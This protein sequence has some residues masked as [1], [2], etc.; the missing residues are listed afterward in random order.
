MKPP[1][2][3]L[4]WQNLEDHVRK[5]ASL[6]WNCPARPEKVNGVRLDAV[7]KT[8]Q[9]YWIIIEISRESKLSKLRNDLSKFSSVRPHLFEKGIYAKSF[10]CCLKPTESLIETGRGQNVEVLSPSELESNFF[11]YES[12]YH[13]RSSQKFGSA[14]DPYSGE[15][16]TKPYIEVE[17]FERG[18]S[19]SYG[20]DLLGRWL[21]DGRRIVLLGGFGSGKSRCA[22]E[23]FEKT[24]DLAAERYRYPVAIDLR[25]HWGLKRKALPHLVWIPAALAV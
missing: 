14:V 9:D 25:E 19:R 8:Q 24:K 18:T 15:P 3:D 17:Y 1:L 21:L 12:Y 10:F 23:L 20:L 4:S 22:M 6:K 2:D 16:D 11:N 13:R 7:L 5:I